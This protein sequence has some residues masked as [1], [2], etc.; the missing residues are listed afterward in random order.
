MLTRCRFTGET[1]KLR[2][3]P[4]IGCEEF[5]VH[6]VVLKETS[7]FFQAVVK[8]EWK[9]G[10]ERVIELPEDTPEVVSAYVDWLYSDK[11]FPRT[12]ELPADAVM[13]ARESDH[14]AKLYVF[15]E[16]NQD[17]AFCDAVITA[18]ARHLDTKIAGKYYYFASDCIASLYAGTS[19]SSPARKF[20]VQLFVKYGR[21][22]WLQNDET[23]MR[24]GLLDF[25][26]DVAIEQ[27]KEVGSVRAQSDVIFDRRREWFKQK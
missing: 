23:F 1:F 24:V 16:K 14:L 17:D 11:I 9:E 26:R 21:K 12:G 6:E 19:S 15:G 22:Q 20:V 5:S 25:F 13:H 8:K 4:R 3:G 10:S 18:W 2:V 7:G 27:F